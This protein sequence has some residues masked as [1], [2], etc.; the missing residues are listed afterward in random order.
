MEALKRLSSSVVD[1][2]VP[3]ED[4]WHFGLDGSKG[5]DPRD[6]RGIALVC[7]TVIEQGLQR[8]LETKLTR[9]DAGTINTLFKSDGAPLQSFDSRLRLAY[10]LGIIGDAAKSDLAC[11]KHIRNAFAHAH[12]DVSFETPEI[13]EACRQI[14][15]HDRVPSLLR[16]AATD[17]ARE[18]YIFA[19][20]GLALHL[21]IFDHD[22]EGEVT[23]FDLKHEQDRML[24]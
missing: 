4:I 13:A 8:A 21:I 22:F 10:A 1:Y 19:C 16:A 2:G 17:D 12:T 24:A 14:T 7:G 20:Y 23:A 5:R 6:D 15:L 9:R 18:R 11:I 3:M